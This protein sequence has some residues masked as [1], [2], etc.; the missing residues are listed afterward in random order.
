M[1]EIL[2]IGA[3]SI[4][5]G[6]I[7]E[8]WL[9]PKPRSVIARCWQANWIHAGSLF[10]V[11]GL[12][13]ALLQRPWLALA[14]TAGL[15]VLLVIVNQ[16]KYFHLREPFIASDWKYFVDAIRYP[17]LYLSYFGVHKAA[18][19]FVGFIVA[20][21]MWLWVE[22]A[23]H[24]P[25]YQ[26]ILIG[27][28]VALF[29][30]LITRWL[31]SGW[32]RENHVHQPEHD[33]HEWGLMASLA[34]YLH[35]I[36]STKP[37]VRPAYADWQH[38]SSCAKP[39]IVCIQAESFFDLNRHFPGRLP[40]DCL[41]H[42]NT[43][44][45]EAWKKGALNVPAWGANTVRTE[46]AF[47]SGLSGQQL[48]VHQFQ[49]YQLARQNK[50]PSLASFLSRHGYQTY[51]VHPYDRRFYDR[52]EVMPNLGFDYF[53]DV[54]VFHADPSGD[55][56]SDL[57]LAE[58]L[59]DILHQAES[60]AFLQVVTMAGHGPYARSGTRASELLWRY[61]QRM[62]KTDDML[63]YLAKALPSLRRPVVLCVYGD[64][65]PSLPEVYAWLGTPDGTTDYLVWHS[66]Q[67]YDSLSAAQD[68]SMLSRDVL[69]LAGFGEAKA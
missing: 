57:A 52:H 20:V 14:L 1:A 62:Q 63:G 60:P 33:I 51:F 43:L 55:D 66:H 36:R 5:L 59:I 34:C 17:S 38:G 41:I 27:L 18:L 9:T 24:W 8:R 45:A 68:A 11:Y 23:W 39:H 53:H 37:D 29:G 16:A 61:A 67:Q 40:Q 25:A 56:V 32:K 44:R 64:H 31:L 54:S 22:P 28:T 10:A 69:T 46:F 47:L 26:N 48:G 35:D 21:S 50:L 30:W 13:F 6:W 4:V 3:L 42:W 58:H 15:P 19:L 2:I 12:Y 65:P 49:P 7:A